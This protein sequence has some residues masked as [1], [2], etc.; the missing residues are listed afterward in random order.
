MSWTYDNLAMANY[1]PLAFR[2]TVAVVRVIRDLMVMESGDGLNFALG[3]D[4]DW[5]G[6]GN[7]LGIMDAFTHF[8]RVT[9]EL[10]YDP[11]TTEITREM[12]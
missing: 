2:T 10:R 1:P 12:Y 9:Y 4:Q 6:S 7:P 8:G 5:P 11:T 3:T